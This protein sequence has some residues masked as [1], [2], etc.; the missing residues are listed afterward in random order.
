MHARSESAIARSASMSFSSGNTL[1]RPAPSFLDQPDKL[2]RFRRPATHAQQ[3][4]IS[5]VR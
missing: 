3:F 1:M 2:L 4:R 5:A